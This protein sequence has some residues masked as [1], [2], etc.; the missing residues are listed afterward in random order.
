MDELLHELNGSTVFTKLDLKWGFHQIQLAPE[1]RHITT[2]TTHHGLYRYKRLMFGISSAPEHYQKII[3]DVLKKCEG[4]ANIADNIVVHGRMPE[5]HDQRLLVVLRCLSEA[6]LTL[7]G[8][9]C[10]FR[11]N[12]LTF[13]GHKLTSDG[14]RPSEEKVAAVENAIAPTT[15]TEV[16]S[17]LGLVQ[18]CSRFISDLATIAEPIQSLTRK[19]AQFAWGK[20]QQDALQK[21]KERI[22]TAETLA[23]FDTSRETRVVADAS[24]YGL[25]AVLT[26][27]HGSHWRVVSFASRSLTD[28]ERQ[29]S[30]TEREALAL[31]WSCERFNLYL[32]GR[33]FQL[34]TDHKP[35]QFIYSSKSKPS[36]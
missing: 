24:P 4:I 30:Q 15:V 31:V 28:V 3:R 5:E 34:E 18:Y 17:F 33:T 22:T 23:Y 12:E 1:S 16:R 25:G 8:S 6:G 2:F 13:Y 29:Y 20:A 14:V 21:L 11:L 9:K 26:Q 32:Y 27:R 36:A 35:L 10:A 7:N 19:N